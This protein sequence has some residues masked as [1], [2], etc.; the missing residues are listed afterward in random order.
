VGE[1][2][3]ALEAP[4]CRLGGGLPSGFEFCFELCS[5]AK[6]SAWGAAC[7]LVLSSVLSS[8]VKRR[9][10]KL[11]FLLMVNIFCLSATTVNLFNVIGFLAAST[12]DFV[13]AHAL[14]FT[15]DVSLQKQNELT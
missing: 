14:Y 12:G 8:V 6:R 10:A 11:A 3:E 4:W 1:H 2:Y 5:E 15:I 13:H 7:R 9:G